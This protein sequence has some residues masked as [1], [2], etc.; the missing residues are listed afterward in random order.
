MG[1]RLDVARRGFVGLVLGHGEDLTR[2]VDGLGDAVELLDLPAQTRAFAP[3]L[4]RPLRLGPQLRVR[5][6]A[7]DLLESFLL[8]SVLKETPVKR[9]CAL[10]G[11]AAVV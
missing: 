9:R 2:I 4:L 6:L 1:V 11:R 7:T 10:R 8:L 3:E 5:E